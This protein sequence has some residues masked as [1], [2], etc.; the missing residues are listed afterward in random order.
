MKRSKNTGG[1]SSKVSCTI[2]TENWQLKKSKHKQSKS[3]KFQEPKSKVIL[4]P[5]YDSSPRASS[6]VV[7]PVCLWCLLKCVWP[8]T[9][10]RE[11][12]TVVVLDLCSCSRLEVKD[13]L[14]WK[15]NWRRLLSPSVAGW[16]LK[17]VFEKCSRWQK[18]L[19]GHN[20]IRQWQSL[21]WS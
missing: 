9:F 14:W 19:L 11:C 16:S 5:F 7:F 4:E 21:Q 15:I 18:P 2:S 6:S 1:R 12:T 17:T 13:G 10:M 20:L 8:H 3:K